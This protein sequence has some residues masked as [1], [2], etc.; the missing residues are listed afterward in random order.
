MR[1]YGAKNEIKNK[2]LKDA[3]LTL[4]LTEFLCKMTTDGF[5]LTKDLATRCFYLRTKFLGKIFRVYLIKIN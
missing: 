3:F 5:V 1:L 4:V 2:T